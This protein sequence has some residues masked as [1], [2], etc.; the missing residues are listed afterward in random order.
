MGMGCFSWGGVGAGAGAVQIECVGL[1]DRRV[2]CAVFGWCNCNW[3]F[4]SCTNLPCHLIEEE[5]GRGGELGRFE[6]EGGEGRGERKLYICIFV[7]VI[8]S[9]SNLDTC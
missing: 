1:W 8:V 4:A 7:R 2:L 3:F 9:V 6:R 5:C